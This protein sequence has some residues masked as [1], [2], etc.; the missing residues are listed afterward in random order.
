MLLLKTV[1]PQAANIAMQYFKNP[2]KQWIKNDASVVSEAD[3]KVNEYLQTS[4]LAQRPDYG[5][6]S[7]ESEHNNFNDKKVV[8]FIVDPID[9]TKGF[10]DHSPY[11]CIGVA[12]EENNQIVAAAIICPAL[13]EFYYGAKGSSIYF[14]DKVFAPIVKSPQQELVLALPTKL[15]S[16]VKNKKFNNFV[17]YGYVPSL[18]YKILLCARGLIDVVVIYP[19]CKIWDIAAAHLFLQHSKGSLVDYNNNE[20]DYYHL[21]HYEQYLFACKN[22]SYYQTIFLELKNIIS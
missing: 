21:G 19:S 5:W 12:I 16:R 10:L 2:V 18:L 6:I 4:L 14:N 20:V 15:L 9:G 1:L 11:W 17:L 3:I 22:N 8:N 7:E 13:N